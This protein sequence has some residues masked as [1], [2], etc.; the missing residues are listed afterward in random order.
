MRQVP[1]GLVSDAATGGPSPLGMGGCPTSLQCHLPALSL[2]CT[3]KNKAAS[4]L[5]LRCLGDSGPWSALSSEEGRR[6][7][8][9]GG[10]LEA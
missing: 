9:K 6:H 4:L 2:G 10:I 5:S 8:G 7:F 3:E 1:W